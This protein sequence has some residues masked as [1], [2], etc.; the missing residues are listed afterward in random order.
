MA[1]ALH[2]RG[3]QRFHLPR[4]FLVFVIMAQK[5]QKAVNKQ[6]RDVLPDVFFLRLGL[7]EN[8]VQRQRDIP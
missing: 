2:N 5:M 7:A 3:F 4:L 6:M 1:E 8:N